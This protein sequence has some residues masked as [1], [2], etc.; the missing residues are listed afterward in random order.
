MSH[1]V[2]RPLKTS[3]P[4]LFFYPEVGEVHATKPRGQVRIE[5]QYLTKITGFAVIDLSSFPRGRMS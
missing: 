2:G 3:K 1:R 4:F 5:P